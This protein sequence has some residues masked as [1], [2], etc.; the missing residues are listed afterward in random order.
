MP[1][2]TEVVQ[3]EYGKK[4]KKQKKEKRKIVC[5]VGFFENRL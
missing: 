3:L 1:E 2:W 5:P 4:N